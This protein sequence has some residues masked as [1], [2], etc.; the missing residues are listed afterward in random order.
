MGRFKVEV[1]L[2]FAHDLI[3]RAI[4]LEVV[5]GG[6][7]FF[8]GRDPVSQREPRQPAFLLWKQL[9]VVITRWW[10]QAETPNS[11]QSFEI[12]ERELID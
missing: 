9:S 4:G 1:L 10:P 2:E 3:F 5:V 7:V 11:A 8:H 6:H 12:M